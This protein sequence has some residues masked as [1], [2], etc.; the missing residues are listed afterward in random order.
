[1]PARGI[2]PAQQADGLAFLQGLTGVVERTGDQTLFLPKIDWKL[3]N[4]HSLAVTYNRLRWDSPGRRADRGRRQSRHR[5]LGQ[6]RR[7]RRLDDRAVDLGPR[8]ASMTN[9]VR[10]QWGR[11]F[12]FQ[13]SQEPIPGEPV[14]AHRPHAPGHDHRA[15]PGSSSASRT[16]SSAVVSGRAPHRHRRHLHAVAGL[17]HL[18]KIGADISRVSDTLDNLFQE[19]G[20]Y[21]YSSRVD[22]ITDY[23]NM[24]GRAD[25]QLHAASTRA[26]ARPRSTSDTFDYDVFIQDT[27]HANPR[28]TLNLGLR[29]DYEQMPEP[30]IPNPL[31]HG[32]ARCS[33]GQEQLRAADRR[34]RT[35]SADTGARSSAADTGCS[36]AAS[37]TRRSRTPSPTSGSAAGQLQLAL[38]NTS[39]GAPTFPNILASA[40]A[41]PVRPDVVVFERRH[42]EPAR[43]RVR[44]DPRAADRPRH[45]GLGVLRRQRGP[46]SAAV[47]RHEPARAVGHGDLRG[48]AAVRSTARPSRRRSSPARG[49]TPNF[50]RITNI[51]TAVDSKYNG[52]VLQLNRRLSNGLQFQASYTEARATDNGQCSQTFTSGNNVLNPV[53]PR[54]RRRHVELRDSAPVRRQRDLD[55]LGR[56]GGQ[57]DARAVFRLHHF[58]DACH[59]LWR[60]VHRDAHR[61]HAEHARVSRPVFWARAA[62]TACR[63]FARNNYTLPRP[64]TIDL[65][66]SRGFALQ[67]PHKVEG[68]LDVFNL[69]N[70]LN[71]TQ[72]N[73]LMYTVGGTVA[74]PTLTYNPT[75]SR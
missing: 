9:E 72:A 60:S 55:A 6:R 12:E 48:A 56:L 42:A 1:M 46:Q 24:R 27:W 22:F 71:Y 36:T 5:E 75:S 32:H 69:T 50:G 53:R 3:N 54:A 15:P 29:Y 66:V 43:S 19:G 68:I 25:A 35:T 73:T 65:R 18:I 26:S 11:D 34:R 39:A 57:H 4:N 47:H 49:R 67:A 70:R 63:R 64:R 17:A 38:Q 58:A 62:R 30:Q 28:T 45:D 16:S 37:S 14:S 8:L 44:S 40:S 31:L 7:A 59:V 61:Q 20:A 51:S 33:R 2:S 10:F 52:L 21:A 13:S 74:A 41:T 23:A